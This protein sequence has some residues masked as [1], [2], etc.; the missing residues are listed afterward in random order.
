MPQ[1]RPGSSVRTAARDRRPVRG[2]EREAARGEQGDRPAFDGPDLGPRQEVDQRL[3]E[4][5]VEAGPDPFEPLDLV[6]GQRGAPPAPQDGPELRDGREADAVVDAVDVPP[7]IDR[8]DVAALAIRVVHHRVQDRHAAEPCVVLDDHG[9]DVHLGIRL[10]EGLDHPLAEW[11][12]AQDCRRHDP[13]TARLGDV[14]GGHLAAGQR[15]VREVVERAL[16]EGRLVDRVEDERGLRVRAGPDHRDEHRV[17]RRGDDTPDDLDVAFAQGFKRRPAVEHGCGRLADVES[18][19]RGSVVVHHVRHHPCSQPPEPRRSGGVSTG[20][21]SRPSHAR[22]YP[23]MPT[24]RRRHVYPAGER[25]WGSIFG[26]GD[27]RHL[28][29][30][31]HRVTAPSRCPRLAPSRTLTRPPAPTPEPPSSVKC[32]AVGADRGAASGTSRD[33]DGRED[34]ASPRGIWKKLAPTPASGPTRTSHRAT[35]ETGDFR[36]GSPKVDLFGLHA[37]PGLSPIEV[38]KTLSALG[39]CPQDCE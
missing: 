22:V 25:W 24:A 12:V 38:R 7:A 37:I 32:A 16:A 15:P 21:T 34:R 4:C 1:A 26:T 9:H 27:A 11:P 28:R 6:G 5:V 3:A 33:V 10:D 14:P 23:Q 2:G 18:G 39:I 36:H 13:P 29:P 19:V 8:Q 30:R 17:V 20:Q 31:W 35:D